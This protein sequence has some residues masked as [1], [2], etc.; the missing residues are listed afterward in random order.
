M[1]SLEAFGGAYSIVELDKLID[2]DSI[3]DE[4]LRLILDAQ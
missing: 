4:A 3:K 1:A 2:Q